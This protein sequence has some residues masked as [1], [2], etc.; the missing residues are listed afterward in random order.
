L[1][2]GLLAIEIAPVAG[3]YAALPIPIE[4]GE[5]APAG[6]VLANLQSYGKPVTVHCVEGHHAQS[7][8][9]HQEQSKF[10]DCVLHGA[11]SD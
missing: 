11:G 10:E 3:Q 6:A 2:V 4:G 8:Q 5:G 1:L 7:D 9:R